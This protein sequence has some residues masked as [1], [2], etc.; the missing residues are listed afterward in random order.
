MASYNHMVYDIS[1]SYGLDVTNYDT[2]WDVGRA[3]R[4]LH[5]KEGHGRRPRQRS[6]LRA[7]EAAFCKTASML[8][9]PAARS[10]AGATTH[11]PRP[12][13]ETPNPP[14]L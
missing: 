6:T 7:F 5:S 9:P 11:D 10:G 3:E 1:Q 12:A 4:D 2:Y 14:S 8:G 13:D